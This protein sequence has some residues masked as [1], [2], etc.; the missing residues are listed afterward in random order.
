MPKITLSGEKLAMAMAHA[1][2]RGMTFEEYVQEYVQLVQEEMKKE[3]I[4]E[5]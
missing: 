2:E 4:Q 5:K 3:Q 1:N